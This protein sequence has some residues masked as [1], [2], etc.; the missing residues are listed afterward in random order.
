MAVEDVVD[1]E[2][3]GEWVVEEDFIDEEDDLD[4]LDFDVEECIEELVFTEVWSVVFE[5]ECSEDVEIEG[6]DTEV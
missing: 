5:E 6:I 3:V 1:E 2:D 4:E